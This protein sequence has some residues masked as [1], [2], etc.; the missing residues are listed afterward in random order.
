MSSRLSGVAK[1]SGIPGSPDGLAR[2]ITSDSEW[3][4]AEL[5][6]NH[7][8]CCA[9]SESDDAALPGELLGAFEEWS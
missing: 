5:D 6:V 4:S 3:H 9:M 2:S 7:H 8:T 1:R